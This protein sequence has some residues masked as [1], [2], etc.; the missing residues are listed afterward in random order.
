M[1][2]AVKLHTLQ[3]ACDSLCVMS[4]ALCEHSGVWAMHNA[5]AFCI[6]ACCAPWLLLQAV[7]SALALGWSCYAA[8]LSSSEPDALVSLALKAVAMLEQCSKAAAEAAAKGTGPDT[9]GNI[10]VCLSG[11]QL[12]SRVWILTLQPQTHARADLHLSAA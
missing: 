12:L 8:S 9:S 2:A 11:A 1:R 10:G 5:Y 4:N 6:T 7:T 3:R